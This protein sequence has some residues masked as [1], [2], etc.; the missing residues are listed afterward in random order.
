MNSLTMCF[1]IYESNY[2]SCRVCQCKSHGQKT[3]FTNWTANPS[4]FRLQTNN[5]DTKYM[6]LHSKMIFYNKPINLPKAKAMTLYVVDI[7]MASKSK[8]GGDQQ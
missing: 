4:I 8:L 7:R 3:D 1:V 5:I 2:S 6:Y